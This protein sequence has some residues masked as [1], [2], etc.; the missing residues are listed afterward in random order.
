MRLS[1]EALAALDAIDRRG[2]F[3]AAGLELDRV[4]SAITYT[5]RRMEEDLDVLLFD[6]RGHRAQFTPAGRTLLAE[7]RVLLAAA[8]DIE[9][10]VRRVATGWEAELRIAVD[11]LIPLAR[12]FPLIAAFDADCRALRSA[13][14]QLRIAREVLG[15][16]WDALAE[17]RADLVLGASGDAPAGGGYRLRVLADTTSV[18]AVAPR[19]PLATAPEPLT[20]ADIARH[21][22]VVVTDTSRR[23]APRSMGVL[24]GQDTL[25]VPDLE[26]KL[27]AQV[28]GLGCGFLPL[29][30][31]APHLA[32]GRLVARTVETPRPPQRV[33]AAWRTPRPGKA[34]A[35]WIDAI[36]QADWRFLAVAPTPRPVPRAPG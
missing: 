9:Q 25:A 8:G 27:A 30:L 15:G 14:T 10:R 17:G 1:L 33:H 23:L 4:P 12:V 20:E 3:A 24:S 36:G 21:R 32:A 31:A 6:R 34:L 5:V 19:H 29:A 18:F 13:H 26:A 35:W 16:T 11:T 7:G 28:L 22:A 2:S